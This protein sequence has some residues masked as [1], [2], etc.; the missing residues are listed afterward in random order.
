MKRKQ[1]PVDSRDLIQ[2]DPYLL[3]IQTRCY[4]RLLG[5][6]RT[7]RGPVVEVGSGPGIVDLVDPKVIRIDLEEG[8]HVDAVAD[9]AE[10]PLRTNSVG[11][12]ICKDSLHHIS[13]IPGFLS[14]CHRV[15]TRG[16]NLVVCEPNDG[17]LAS[18]VYRFLHREPFCYS[19][20]PWDRD[21]R[22]LESGNQALPALLRRYW[23]NGHPAIVGRFLFEDLGVDLGPS[24]LLSGGI[25]SRTFIP[26]I[27]LLHLDQIERRWPMRSSS[28]AQ[29]WKLTKST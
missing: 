9:A 13:D 2:R 26:S 23:M 22:F 21:P 16:G 25:F 19:D 8:G 6:T 15:L 7:D 28:F 12:I 27:V 18:F 11:S 4:R 20:D 3:E 29:Y 24:F 10:L 14:E 1:R 5:E 17:T